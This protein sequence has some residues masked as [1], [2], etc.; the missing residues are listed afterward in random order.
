M[1]SYQSARQII[2]EKIRRSVA[3]VG[4][5]N[6]ALSEASA[7]VLAADILADRDYPPF[8]RSTRDGYGV[9]A[10]EVFDGVVLQCV[11]EIKAGDVPSVAIAEG[12]CLH[13]MTGAGMAAG[14]DAVV[15][16]EHASR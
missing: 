6:V 16:V 4:V 10:V 15:M 13:I 7:R 5:Q 2:V 9:R 3:E 12:Q 8:D 14:V 11:G 1:I